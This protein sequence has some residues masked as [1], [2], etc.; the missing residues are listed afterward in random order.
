MV[1][2]KRVLLPTKYTTNFAH[3]QILQTA[4]TSVCYLLQLY[5]G[6]KYVQRIY[7]DLKFNFVSS[8]W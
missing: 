5:S 7:M 2:I 4:A 3:P 8:K 6:G 1:Y